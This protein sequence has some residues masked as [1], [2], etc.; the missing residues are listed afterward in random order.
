[1]G[2]TKSILT[3]TLVVITAFVI[4]GPG[5]ANA[6]APPLSFSYQY[7][8]L[9]PPSGLGARGTTGLSVP[10]SSIGVAPATTGASGHLGPASL[11]QGWALTGASTTITITVKDGT[12]SSSTLDSAAVVTLYNSSTGAKQVKAVAS[13][14][15][16][17]TSTRGYYSLW[18]TTPS[19]SYV[20]FLGEIRPFSS[21]AAYTI[22]LVPSTGDTAL[23]DNPSSATGDIWYTPG[24][25][26]G[27][28]TSNGT[29]QFEVDLLNGSTGHA[30]LA[31]AYTS[32]NGSVEFTHVNTAYDYMLWVDGYGQNSSG[33]KYYSENITTN[34]QS[35]GTKTVLSLTG[36][37]QA[38]NTAGGGPIE[39]RWSTTGTVTGG[40]FPSAYSGQ[41]A[42]GTVT[43]TGGTSY[44]STVIGGTLDLVDTIAYV[45]TTWMGGQLSNVHLTNSSLLF[46]QPY[47]MGQGTAMLSAWTYSS[48]SLI[49]VWGQ[50]GIDEAPIYANNSVLDIGTGGAAYS[51]VYPQYWYNDL[52]ENS[53]TGATPLT[54]QSVTVTNTS[55]GTYLSQSAGAFTVARSEITGF[56]TMEEAGA[57]STT[58]QTS[59]V[60]NAT[61][62]LRG[63]S[64][65]HLQNDNITGGTSAGKQLVYIYSQGSNPAIANLTMNNTFMELGDIQNVEG[66]I[67][68]Q[69]NSTYIHN[70]ILLNPVA[71]LTWLKTSSWSGHY[72]VAGYSTDWSI[73][74]YA[75]TLTFTNN[76]M[77]WS[78]CLNGDSSSDLYL[79]L[80]GA[81]YIENNDFQE[82]YSP[83]ALVAG[84]TTAT[85]II[86]NLFG[87]T[88]YN[89][90]LL[91]AI[92][93]DVPGTWGV[94]PQGMG[95]YSYNTRSVYIENDTFTG[96]PMGNQGMGDIQ[97]VD[98]LGFVN[99]WTVSG[100]I[101]E[102]TALAKGT[103]PFAAPFG[104]FIYITGATWSI[105]NSWFL[106]LNNF[107]E[108]IGNWGGN[109][110]P[111]SIS[112]SGDHLFVK[113]QSWTSQILTPNQYTENASLLMYGMPMV[114]SSVVAYSNA[115][116]T[117]LWNESHAVQ[118]V[119]GTLEWGHTMGYA[120]DA[121]ETSSGISVGYQNGYVAGPQPSFFYGGFNYSEAVEPL[122]VQIGVNS[123]RA[124][125]VTVAFGGL[126]VGEPYAYTVYNATSGAKASGA[127]NNYVYPNA[128]G[129]INLSYEPSSMPLNSDFVLDPAN[130]IG[131]IAGGAGSFV[132]ILATAGGVILLGTAF[133]AYLVAT[134]RREDGP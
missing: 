75:K 81:A 14:V 54:M 82:I 107:T 127:Q 85:Y 52:I 30:V 17:F 91:D 45:N 116:G 111:A 49:A 125:N 130:G 8:S 92:G 16:T 115:G 74:T 134:N 88:Y 34:A 26:L 22:Y 9:T 60:D 35:F 98:F 3:A 39:P 121:L 33:W 84:N 38:E 50:G 100:C 110:K 104:P 51:S 56:S 79:N 67:L 15:V 83:G 12:T 73:E 95:I 123:T 102:G 13:G 40:T 19:T 90:T 131:A 77:N 114:N 80:T 4:L 53:N 66:W 129:W 29:P 96:P 117:L 99:A 97:S 70:N 25:Q 7:G 5:T 24:W 126:N 62:T 43:I 31:S 42:I 105:T 128:R 118:Y 48:G 37:S 103:T 78:N 44:L 72:N 27:P 23:A 124:P 119:A 21:A 133:G 87:A 1:M 64:F 122:Y 41:W 101:F 10:I 58:L 57:A 94:T 106:D 65:V 55:L 61:L 109:S 108:A 68:D 71:P 46:I 2:G 18:V 28:Y 59:V 132:L 36:N 11:A 112:L 89:Q 69:A 47:D 20:P 76:V 113:P 86:D 32:A 120:P 63:T 6:Q 93:T